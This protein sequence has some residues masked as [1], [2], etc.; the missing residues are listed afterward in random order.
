MVKTLKH[1]LKN[2]IHNY[3]SK[4]DKDICCES[5]MDRKIVIQQVMD[6]Y[7][8]ISKEMAEPDEYLSYMNN[9][10]VKMIGYKVDLVKDKDK[11]GVR[12]WN[13]LDKRMYANKKLQES[14]IA[15]LLQEVPLYFLLSFLGYA[16][17]RL[18][19]TSADH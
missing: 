14:K 18:D 5:D 6:K 17:Y 4:K 16:S 13:T 9:D 15:D 12:L 1:K 3:L 2:K 8:R 10:L 11:E 7:K 19:I